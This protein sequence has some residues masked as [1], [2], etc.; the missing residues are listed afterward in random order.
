MI[1]IGLFMC[2]DSFAIMNYQSPHNL[3]S[4]P[5]R[6]FSFNLLFLWVHISFILQLMTIH[7]S[8][9]TSFTRRKEIKPTITELCLFSKLFSMFVEIRYIEKT[10]VSSCNFFIIHQ[11]YATLRGKKNLPVNKFLMYHRHEREENITQV[12]HQG[13]S[14]GVLQSISSQNSKIK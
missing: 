2:L 4:P 6:N 13:Q 14:S 11:S 12:H 1:E 7:N 10:G 3:K 9:L 8:F 5:N